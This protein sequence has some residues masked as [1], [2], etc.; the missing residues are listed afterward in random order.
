MNIAEMYIS[1][2][3]ELLI[4]MSLINSFNIN[5][6]PFA[7]F[8]NLDMLKCVCKEKKHCIPVWNQTTKKF[9]MLSA[10]ITVI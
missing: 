8:I 6:I 3:L 1:F 7:K 9:K 2:I 10:G 5:R 4:I